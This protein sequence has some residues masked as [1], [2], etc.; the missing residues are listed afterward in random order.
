MFR[1]FTA[2]LF[3][4]F[5]TMHVTSVRADGAVWKFGRST[6]QDGSSVAYA[7]V[8][9]KVGNIATNVISTATLGFTCTRGNVQFNLLPDKV[10]FGSYGRVFKFSYSAGGSPDP[11]QVAIMEVKD[12]AGYTR[13]Y[14]KR[15]ALTMLGQS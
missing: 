2:V 1:S 7:L 3:L 13:E 14:A 4:G 12:G 10:N 6:N 9:T 11:A 15:L 5:L 8:N